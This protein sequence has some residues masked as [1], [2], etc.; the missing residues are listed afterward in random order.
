M[1]QMCQRYGA[2][3]E[4]LRAG[5]PTEEE[6]LAAGAIL[7]SFY[8]GVENVFRVV[9]RHT[10]SLPERES[11]WHVVLLGSMAQARPGR[12]AVISEGLK[13]ELAEYLAFRHVF[14]SAYTHVLGWEKMAPLVKGL[15]GTFEAFRR[16]LTQFMDKLG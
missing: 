1:E 5:V 6:L 4:K 10:G 11:G 13:G 2:L 15:A 3:L 14:R 8:N 16:E 7:Q 12:R 9:A